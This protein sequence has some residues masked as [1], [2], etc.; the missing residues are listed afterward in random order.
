MMA[1]RIWIAAVYRSGSRDMIRLPKSLRRF[2]WASTRLRIW[3]PTYL[4]QNVRP[5][6]RV[7]RRIS[8]REIAAGAR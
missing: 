2:I 3:M 7:A 6:W 5:G 4:F 1:M 8:L